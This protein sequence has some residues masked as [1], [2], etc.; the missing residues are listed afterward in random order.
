MN[1]K[2]AVAAAASV[3]VAATTVTHLIRTRKSAA[4]PE[5]IQPKLVITE[6]AAFALAQD[7]VSRRMLD[8]YYDEKP[9]SEYTNDFHILYANYLTKA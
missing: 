9:D 1:I 5:V 7:E 6:A 2:H 4:T 3:A 8:G